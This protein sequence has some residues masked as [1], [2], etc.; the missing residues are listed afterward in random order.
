MMPGLV[1]LDD[2][3]GGGVHGCVLEDIGQRQG[4]SMRWRLCRDE[5]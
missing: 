4:P 1:D 2:G 5:G 3:D